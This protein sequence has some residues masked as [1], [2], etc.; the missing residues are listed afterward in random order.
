[1]EKNEKVLEEDE[2]TTLKVERVWG[3]IRRFVTNAANRD[4]L[5]HSVDPH[6]I[7]GRAKANMS[8]KCRRKVT[9]TA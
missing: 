1:M 7:R 5:Q 4:M 2:V 6:Q 8:V 3:K 9:A